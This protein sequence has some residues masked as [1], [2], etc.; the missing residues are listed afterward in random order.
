M[1]DTPEHTLFHCVRWE[2]ERATLSIAVNA[3]NFIGN[4]ISSKEAFENLTRF[5]RVVMKKKEQE[6]RDRQRRQEN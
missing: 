1:T 3:E 5:L 4:M 2:N 6:E